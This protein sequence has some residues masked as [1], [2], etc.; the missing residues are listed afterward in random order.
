MLPQH[1]LVT[2][3]II[4]LTAI[5]RKTMFWFALKPG[6]PWTALLLVSFPFPAPMLEPIMELLREAPSPPPTPI[7]SA[8]NNYRTHE[9]IVK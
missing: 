4:N 2:F 8:Y 3:K 6:K 7:L 9:Y 1:D 5:H